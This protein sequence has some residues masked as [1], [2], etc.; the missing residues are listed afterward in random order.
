M[1]RRTKGGRALNYHRALRHDKERFPLYKKGRFHTLTIPSSVDLRPQDSPIFDQG[2][3][4]SCTANAACGLA[5]FLEIKKGLATNKYKNPK[6][7]ISGKFKAASRNFVY[8]NE[9]AQLNTKDQDS[10]AYLHNGASV[11]NTIGAPAETDYPYGA[12][13]LYPKPPSE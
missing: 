10:G 5:D 12:N 8:W 4:G 1:T 9:R 7:Y 11:F 3:E 6:E 13:T 2:T